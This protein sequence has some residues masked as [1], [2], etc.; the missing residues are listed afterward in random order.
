MLHTQHAK[1]S[2]RPYKTSSS[3]RIPFSLL[4]HHFPASHFSAVLQI[5]VYSLVSAVIFHPQ[6]YYFLTVSCNYPSIYIL[7]TISSYNRY[8]LF[9]RV[10]QELTPDPK[11]PTHL[12][13]NSYH[14]MHSEQLHWINLP[15]TLF[16]WH[17]CYYCPHI[18]NPSPKQN[19]F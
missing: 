6:D 16:Q 11:Q 19:K 10:L 1:T 14:L 2:E 3:E 13:T 5:L 15:N 8:H 17:C 4:F 12:N 9:S 18:P 7:I